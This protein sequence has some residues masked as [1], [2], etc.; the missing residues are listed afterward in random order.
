MGIR[1]RISGFGGELGTD[2]GHLSGNKYG[3]RDGRG[4]VV[5]IQI[6]TEVERNYGKSP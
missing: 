1:D 3:I 5:V 6:E 2:F 4:L